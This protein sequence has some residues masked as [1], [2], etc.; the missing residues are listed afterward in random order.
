[1]LLCS[2]LYSAAE[3]HT[4]VWQSLES[5]KC[6]HMHHAAVINLRISPKRSKNIFSHE[7]PPFLPASDYLF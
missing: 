5:K 7:L 4:L 2:Y 3:I 6:V 1:M